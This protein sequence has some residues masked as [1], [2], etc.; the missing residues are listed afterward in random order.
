MMRKCRLPKRSK[1]F[2]KD[3]RWVIPADLHDGCTVQAI[4]TIDPEGPH[5]LS[6]WNALASPVVTLFG[7]NVLDTV[8]ELRDVFVSHSFACYQR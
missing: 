3:Y 7:E 1:E 4:N 2:S 5:L 6:H 8:D